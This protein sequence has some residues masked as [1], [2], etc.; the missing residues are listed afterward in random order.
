MQRIND[1]KRLRAFVTLAELLHFGRTAERLNIAQPALSQQ[2]QQ[3]ERDVGAQLLLRDRRSVQLTP[4]GALF[5]D[6]ARRT[7]DEAEKAAAI[8]ARANRG[9]I[10]EI[11]ISHV[12]SL[13]YSGLMSRICYACRQQMPDV[14]LGVRELD[15]EPQ[16]EALAN[17][18]VDVA[19]IRLP[20]GPLPDGIVTTT[21]R[22]ESVLACLRDDHAV[23]GEAV[24][25]ADLADADFIGT[26]LRAGLGFYDTLLRI[27]EAAGFAP[28]VTHQS[29]HFPTIVSL[30]AAGRGVALV[31]G[32][33]ARL[34]L[35][36]VRYWPLSGVTTTSAV[37]IAH[38]RDDPSPAVRRFIA[39]SKELAPSI[40][41]ALRETLP[42]LPSDQ[43][44]TGR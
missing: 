6:G 25:V 32:P 39:L 3:L 2:I 33:V 18:Q 29:R 11:E 26:H 4:V 1:L 43:V 27:C 31:P 41:V 17:G 37:G 30:V 38:R 16:L 28:R 10:G 35:P 44:R 19:F 22:E 7:L 8:V 34:S 12:S 36:D 42:G 14:R 24:A 40:D 15:L 9:E 23:A 5:L 21:L 13:A 20:A